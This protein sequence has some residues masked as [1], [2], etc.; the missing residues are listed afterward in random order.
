MHVI[1]L[2]K[3]VH[4]ISIILIASAEYNSNDVCIVGA[5]LAALQI[6]H[7]FQ[8]RDVNYIIFE[9]SNRVGKFFEHFPRHRKLISLNKIYTGQKNDEFNMRHDWNSIYTTDEEF[10]ISKFSKEFFP[11]A[12]DFLDYINDFYQKHKF[13]VRFNTHINKVKSNGD[14]FT[15]VKKNGLIHDCG[16]VIIATGVSESNKLDIVGK[17]NI[18]DY[19][20]L[21]TDPKDYINKNVLI[22]GL[23][24]SAFETA[25]S[26]YSHTASVRMV[27][28]TRI[29]LSWETHYVGDLR[30][31]NNSPLD[32]YMLKS[33]DT[34]NELPLKNMSIVKRSDG[35]LDVD[36]WM[37][38]IDENRNS[39]HAEKQDSF[40][41][42]EPFDFVLNCIGFHFDESIL[43]E[44]LQPTRSGCHGKYPSMKENYESNIVPNLFYA[45][46]IGHALDHRKAAGAFIHGFR[47]TAKALSHIV[48][49]RIY[50]R[51]WPSRIY[52]ISE[53]LNTVIKRVSESS[54]LYQMYGIYG[55][56][57]AIRD[58]GETFEHVKEFPLCNLANFEES[59]GIHLDKFYATFMQLGKNFSGIGLDTFYYKRIIDDLQDSHRVNFI[60][61]AIYY[62]E[63]VPTGEM[64]NKYHS[65][66]CLCKPKMAHFITGDAITIWDAPIAHHLLTRKFFQETLKMDLRHYTDENCYKLLLKHGSLPITCRQ[67]YLSNKGIG[68]AF[69][70]NPKMYFKESDR[71][72]ERQDDPVERLAYSLDVDV[73]KFAICNKALGKMLMH[74]KNV[75]VLFTLYWEPRSKIAVYHYNQM[76]NHYKDRFV[77]VD[78]FDWIRVC[79]KYNIYTYPSV[80]IIDKSK[81]IDI[82]Q[83]SINVDSLEEYSKMIQ[84]DAHPQVKNK[85]ACKEINCSHSLRNC[86]NQAQGQF[87]ISSKMDDISSIISL[88]ESSIIK[89]NIEKPISF[90]KT[91][92]DIT[93]C[94]YDSSKY[95]SI[96]NWLHECA[97]GNIMTEYPIPKFTGYD[98]I[99]FYESDY[100]SEKFYTKDDYDYFNKFGFPPS[101]DYIDSYKEAAKKYKKQM[102]SDSD[103]HNKNM[104]NKIKMEL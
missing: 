3:C 13:N 68:D 37:P 9:K 90:V 78:C 10:R 70:M 33:L 23:G 83:N 44:K 20:D 40:F 1:S 12:D 69:K 58:N 53:L 87:T 77:V 93:I 26:I 42:R 103:D 45:G 72:E 11:M 16:S 52:P 8:Q 15:L 57:Y 64:K 34:V 25:D 55:D 96:Q 51:K 100:E 28:N 14:R 101:F 49:K 91:A 50:N 74:H 43:E 84:M 86:H 76:K 47:Y 21:S 88:T 46:T 63:K 27:G 24:N 104:K 5:G 85:D 80:V 97:S 65:S 102:N 2:I 31:I 66:Y 62:Y 22:L 92:Q 32:T 82:M 38:V 75:I 39:Y 95:G 89:Q 60:H 71:I 73:K 59:T 4:L 79:E 6:A 30:G 94:Q 35:R 98:Y 56:I 67:H 61:P 17:E 81:V 36:V 54:A 18:I 41:F 7:G 48:E 29:R 19:A 99:Q